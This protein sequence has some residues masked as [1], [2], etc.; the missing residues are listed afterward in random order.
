MCLRYLYI[1]CI[2]SGLLLMGCFAS[3]Q[4]VPIGQWREHVSYANA[5]AVTN[6]PDK[7]YC[8]SAYSLFTVT[9]SD[10][11][12]TRYGKINGLHDVGIA[13]IRYDETSK[14]LL[15]AYKNSNLDILSGE[16]IINIPDIK[17]KNLIG[18][19]RIYDIY[20]KNDKAYLSTGIGIIVVDIK[21]AEINDTYIIGSNS[22]PVKVNSFCTNDTFFFAASTEGIKLAPVSSANLSNY[23]SWIPATRG[24]GTGEATAVVNIGNTV[25]ATK[26]DSLFRW[27]SDGWKFLYTDG[28]P[29]QNTNVSDGKILLCENTMD[30]SARV[31]ILQPNGQLLEVLQNQKEL[32]H[33][34]QAVLAR[35]QVWIADLFRSLLRYQNEFYEPLSPNSPTA[36]ASGDMVFAQQQLW[37]AGGTVDESWNYTYNRNGFY[38]YANDFWNIYNHFNRPYLDTLL[39][40]ITVAVSPMDKTVYLGSFGGGLLELKPNNTYKIYKQNTALDEALGDP[41]SYRISGLGFDA[42]NNLWITSY[43][44]PYELLVK[45]ADNSW[46]KFL[47]PVFHTGNAVGQVL[48]DDH[49]QKWIVSPKG[50]G[51]IVFNH[52]KDI[53]NESDDQWKILKTGAGSGNLP[54]NEV[55]CLAKDR[56]GYIWI[57]TDKGIGIV[58]CPQ[59]VFSGRNCEAILPI[60]QQ[61]NFAGYLFQNEQVNAIAVDGADRKWIGTKNG[62]WLISP[63]GDKT[64]YRFTEDNSPLLSNDVKHIAINPI[65]GEV[66]FA[67]FNGIVSFR[68]TA[69]EGMNTNQEVLVFPNPVP[70]S[71]TGTIAIRGVTENAIVKITDI[72]G[73]LIYQTRALGGQ[74]IWNGKD[75]TGQRAA[76]GVY[77]VFI[78]NDTGSQKFVAKFVFIN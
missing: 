57:G 72:A 64:I 14:N 26:N 27:M 75:Y 4:Q 69:T 40:F 13:T 17:R 32:L 24:M 34:S 54:A 29:I 9:I 47:I 68:S 10:H 45:K 67:T 56:N 8:A 70:P 30:G 62:V 52:G 7:I 74:A 35:G 15:I 41:N 44:A 48:V 11:N 53:D 33:P 71:Y 20:F 61:D 23:S 5:V 73:K 16:N 38:Q 58:Q 6:S 39:D 19:K 42:H 3:A 2:F 31:V 66:F 36:P 22:Q 77:L 60:V 63:E 28:W 18:D 55:R 51:V 46:H 37:V 49:D 65:T 50:N 59:D 43:G 1:L 78:T 76:S 12:I 21:K 25:I